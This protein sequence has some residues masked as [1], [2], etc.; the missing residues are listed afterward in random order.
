MEL[1]SVNRPPD[2]LRE[3]ER[4]IVTEPCQPLIHRQCVCIG[5]FHDGRVKF[6]VFDPA[7]WGSAGTRFEIP[8]VLLPSTV[9]SAMMLS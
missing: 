7:R 5:N 1:H 9:R 6:E 4:L 8:L 2:Q 3:L